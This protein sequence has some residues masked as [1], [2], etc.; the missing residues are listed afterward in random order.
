MSAAVARPQSPNPRPENVPPLAHGQ[1]LR[2]TDAVRRDTR[3]HPPRTPASTLMRSNSGAA[4]SYRHR[5]GGENVNR[6]R[7]HSSIAATSLSTRT[8][9]FQPLF[10]KVSHRTGIMLSGCGLTREKISCRRKRQNTTRR[11]QNITRTRRATMRKRPST[12]RPDITRKQH[13]MLIRREATSFTLE[14]MP[15]RQ[16][17]RTPK[18]TA[19]NKLEPQLSIEASTS[20]LP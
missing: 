11:H 18:S 15:K 7:A 8:D 2:G 3:C 13:T 1:N 17:R 10:S 5:G 14:D 6:W 12:T 20:L 9:L 16:Q 19:R 4:S